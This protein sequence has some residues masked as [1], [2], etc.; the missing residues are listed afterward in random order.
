MGLLYPHSVW[1]ILNLSPYCLW[2]GQKCCS[3][4]GSFLG[5]KQTNKKPHLLA[6]QLCHL[7]SRGWN[8]VQHCLAVVLTHR[9]VTA[10][11]RVR[12]IRDLVGH[13]DAH[14]RPCCC[15]GVLKT[16]SNHSTLCQGLVIPLQLALSYSRWRISAF[17]VSAPW[18]FEAWGAEHLTS[19]RQAEG[20]AQLLELV[21]DRVR[22]FA[23]WIE[24]S[25]NGA[26]RALTAGI[27]FMGS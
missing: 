26:V 23:L 3:I 25:G 10:L 20:E 17:S 21:F 7:L 6:K 27:T 9:D 24:A 16:R 5:R 18:V 19:K 12:W 15:L 1:L 11:K 13:L 2:E 22:F 4:W 8:S 14:V